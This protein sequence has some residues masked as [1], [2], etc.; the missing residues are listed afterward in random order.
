MKLDFDTLETLRRNHPAWRLMLA[1]HAPLVASFLDRVFLQP[2]V[3]AMSQADLSEKLEDELYKLRLNPGENRFPRS[4]AEYLDEWAA[5]NRGWLRKFYPPGSDEPH[6]DLTPA[7]EKALGWL[8]S[9]T[10]RT[11]V[12][13]ESRLMTVFELLRQIIAGSEMDPQVRIAELHRRRAEIDEEL[14]RVVAGDLTLLDDTAVKERFFQLTSTARELLGDFREVENNFRVLDRKVRER[15]ALWDGGRGTL[16]AEIL[17]ER[18]AIE[19]SDQGRSFRAFWDFLMSSSRQEEL[20]ELLSRVLRLPAIISTT[21]DL[22]MRRIHHDWLTAGEQAQ[23]TVA[24]LSQQLR[25]FLDDKMLLE[26]RRIMEIIHQVEEN[27]LGVRDNPP[28]GGQFFEISETS[29]SIELPMERTLFSLPYKPDLLSEVLELGA[30]DVESDALYSQV[31]VDPARLL[32]HIRRALQHKV[33]VSLAEIIR[34]Y[35]LEHGLA[36][37]VTYVALACDD[38]R[39]VIDDQV[40]EEIYWTNSMGVMSV[41]KIPRILFGRI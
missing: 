22:R 3:R 31:V 6:F 38:P 10:E 32:T 19:N 9:L 30:D 37:L 39:C 24:L 12:G 1:D 21:P 5:D 13:T 40:A 29:P 15:I 23:R 16:L 34:E 26:N 17:G 27:A 28:Q 41:A 14:S 7:T 25:R 2:N 4:A 33:Q 18:E 20:S 11:F 35:P 36:E 8:S